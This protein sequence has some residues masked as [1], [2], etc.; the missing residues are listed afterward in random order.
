MSRFSLLF[1]LLSVAC[2]ASATSVPTSSDA[3]NEPKEDP[4]P[5]AA[6]SDTPKA[7]PTP[8][9][10]AGPPAPINTPLFE[11]TIDGAS[12]TPTKMELE[13]HGV[14]GLDDVK[15]EVEGRF[16]LPKG[17]QDR[18]VPYITLDIYTPLLG[19]IPYSK[20]SSTSQPNSIYIQYHYQRPGVSGFPKATGPGMTIV[21]DGRDG[22]FE[23]EAT[24]FF[25]ID[26]EPH[27]FT[28]KIRQPVAAMP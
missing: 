15:G 14:G 23:G 16:E 9:K 12:V 6:T 20:P 4:T 22:W 19:D 24:G 11:L 18:S 1:C 10:D 7:N 3:T 28:L 26:D 21:R 27:P 25:E 17:S 2:T 5:P 8:T 13:K